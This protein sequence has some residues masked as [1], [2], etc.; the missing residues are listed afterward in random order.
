MSNFPIISGE[1]NNTWYVKNQD[2][3]L[4]LAGATGLFDID[5][6]NTC[7][8]K[9]LSVIALTAGLFTLIVY[10]RQA[11]EIQDIME[12]PVDSSETNLIKLRDIRY[13]DLDGQSKLYLT[14]ING[15]GLDINFILRIN[16]V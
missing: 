10:N 16:Y 2:L 6:K 7:L 5:L 13:N 15:S 14:I 11:R 3:G 9:E 4:I 12:L 1:S 8:I